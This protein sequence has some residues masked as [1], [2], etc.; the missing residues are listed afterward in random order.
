MAHDDPDDIEKQ[1]IQIAK[2]AAERAAK[3]KW[4]DRVWTKGLVSRLGEL[5][6]EQKYSIF[7]SGQGGWLYDLVW[8]KRTDGRLTGLPLVLESEWR[9]N[10]KAIDYDFQKL[11]V[12]RADHRVMICQGHDPDR[13]RHFQRFIEQIRD[14]GPQAADR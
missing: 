12:A 7:R 1:I 2:E 8:Q 11:L 14:F 13:D 6:K 9:A 5:G 10:D 4:S 3:E